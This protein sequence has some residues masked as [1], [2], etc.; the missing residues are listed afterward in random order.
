MLRS[1][2]NLW[3]AVNAPTT[4]PKINQHAARSLYTWAQVMPATPR[5]FTDPVIHSRLT[6]IYV[7]LA[8]RQQS[9]S[10]EDCYKYTKRLNNETLAYS[11]LRLAY[12][13]Y[14]KD[15]ELHRDLARLRNY[16]TAER[17][18]QDLAYG[19]QHFDRDLE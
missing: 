18:L 7:D 10:C 3:L 14:C 2:I 11:I 17:F 6:K 13:I 16:E 8:N 9:L 4:I 5:Y 15:S 1:A 12:E 19:E